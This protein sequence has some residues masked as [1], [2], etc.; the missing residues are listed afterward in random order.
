MSCCGKNCRNNCANFYTR[1]NNCLCETEERKCCHSCG[2]IGEGGISSPCYNC[3][4]LCCEDS[5]REAARRLTNQRAIIYSGG[6]KMCVVIVGIG[7][8]FI[9]AINYC[10]NRVVYFNLRRIDN[11]EDVLPRCY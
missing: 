2:P 5:L 9:K 3:N 11:I 8:C 4:D 10:T 1:S 6:C 7:D